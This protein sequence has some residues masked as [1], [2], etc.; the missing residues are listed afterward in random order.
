MKPSWM[1][2]GVLKNL[3]RVDLLSVLKDNGFEGVE[4]RTDANHGHGVEADVNKQKV[5]IGKVL[6]VGKKLQLVVLKK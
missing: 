5:I 3:S 6:M 1:T 4:F 2:Y